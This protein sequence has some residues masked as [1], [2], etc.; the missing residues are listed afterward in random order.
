M[1]FIL[2]PRPALPWLVLTC[3]VLFCPV[4]FC[5]VFS[6]LILSCLVFSSLILYC[7][8]L[9]RDIS[10]LDVSAATSKDS[11]NFFQNCRM[12]GKERRRE[13]Q[14]PTPSSIECYIHITPDA[15]THTHYIHSIYIHTRIWEQNRTEYHPWAVVLGNEIRGDKMRW[16]ERRLH[17]IILLS[18]HS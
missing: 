18:T 15:P 1:S 6:C 4:L 5:L 16:D 9:S 14:H 17:Y 3:L 13:V 12:M 7:V 8:V 11:S 2:Q 10:C